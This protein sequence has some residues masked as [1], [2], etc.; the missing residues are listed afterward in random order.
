M[1]WP[2]AFVV[3]GALLAVTITVCAILY[4]RVVRGLI[5]DLS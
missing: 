3:V 5:K 2:I 1:T 4:A